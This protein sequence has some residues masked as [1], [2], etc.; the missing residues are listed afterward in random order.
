MHLNDSPKE[1]NYKELSYFSKTG[2]KIFFILK[3][4]LYDLM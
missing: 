2:E 1:E 3:H 4:F